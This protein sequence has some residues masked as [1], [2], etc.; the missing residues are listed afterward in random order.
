MKT[1]YTNKLIGAGTLLMIFTM[2][3]LPTSA[4]A[5]TNITTRNFCK[6]LP[7]LQVKVS[8]KI[9][10]GESKLST[11]RTSVTGKLK[12]S[13][14]TR[15]HSLDDARTQANVNKENQFTSLYSKATT[16]RERSAIT[17]FKDTINSAIE[18]RRSAVDTAVKIYRDSVQSLFSTREQDIDTYIATLKSEISSAFVKA[19]TDCIAQVDPATIKS[20]LTGDIKNAQYKFRDS[21]QSQSKIETQVKDL[22]NT[23][24]SA[25]TQ[26]KDN[27]ESTIEKAKATLKASLPITK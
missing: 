24:E 20:T 16:D 6:Q 23:R 19:Q 2:S 14:G 10:L 17:T 9:G 4:S 25:I 11:H 7:S 8:S 1:N 22:A 3:V 15:D 18:T 26:A 5:A 12:D 27:F 21:K 13:W